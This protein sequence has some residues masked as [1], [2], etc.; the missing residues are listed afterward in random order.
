MENREM[1]LDA[2]YQVHRRISYQYASENNGHF[3]V[4][5]AFGQSSGVRTTDGF[6][7]FLSNGSAVFT[8]NGF[9]EQLRLKSVKVETFEAV[10]QV[11]INMRTQLGIPSKEISLLEL[12][13]K[14]K[15]EPP[16]SKETCTNCG[17]R[18]ANEAECEECNGK[19]TCSH[20]G[21][22]CDYCAG[23]GQELCTN[24]NVVV[25][26]TP[27]HDTSCE[28]IRVCFPGGSNLLV[29]RWGLYELL[30]PIAE[31]GDETVVLKSD[32]S[33]RSMLLLFGEGWSMAFAQTTHWWKKGKVAQV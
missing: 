11:V 29:P 9:V 28:R 18:D 10:D 1:K 20:C 5:N 2:F 33:D 27:F 17:Y 32:G 25:V 14:L 23:T 26:T 6:R 24:H 19:G 4:P 16:S 22:E 13:Q 31:V 7:L 30:L 21:K 3:A 15:C 8:E 12:V